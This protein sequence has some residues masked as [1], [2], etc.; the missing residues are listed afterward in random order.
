MSQNAIKKMIKQKKGMIVNIASVYGIKKAAIAAFTA[1]VDETTPK[2]IRL[3]K[4][5]QLC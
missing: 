1:I 2:F 4:Q 3:P 5:A